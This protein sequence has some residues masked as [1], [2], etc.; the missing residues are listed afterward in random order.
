MLTMSGVPL[1]YPLSKY[2]IRLAKMRS[3]V[4]DPVVIS[5]MVVITMTYHYFVLIEIFY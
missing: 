1:F 5:L 3:G 2:P 4:H